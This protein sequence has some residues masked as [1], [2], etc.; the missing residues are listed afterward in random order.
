MVGHNPGTTRQKCL[1]RFGD[2][3]NLPSSLGSTHDFWDSE[4]LRWMACSLETPLEDFCAIIACCCGGKDGDE[5]STEGSSRT[6]RRM[7]DQPAIYNI[8]IW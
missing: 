4:N 6:P 3:M 8:S 5:L 7:I 2:S 1:E